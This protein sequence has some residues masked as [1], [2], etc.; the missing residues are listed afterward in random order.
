MHDVQKTV[1]IIERPTSNK[2]WTTFKEIQK[3]KAE[4]GARKKNRGKFL[5]DLTYTIER[6]TL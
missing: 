4:A 1:R 6:K 2:K 5:P 3:R